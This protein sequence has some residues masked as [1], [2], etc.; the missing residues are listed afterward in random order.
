MDQTLDD[1]QFQA[2]I[3]A[4]PEQSIL[5]IEDLDRAPQFL[6]PEFVDDKEQKNRP[7]V[8][9][10]AMLQ[11]LS[12][13]GSNHDQIIFA[14][15]NNRDYLQDV[16]LRP[17]RVDYEVKFELASPRNL[18]HMFKDVFFEDT[19]DE[20]DGVARDGALF[21]SIVPAKKFSQSRIMNHLISHRRDRHAAIE[22]ARHWAVIEQG[23]E[24]ETKLG[25]EARTNNIEEEEGEEREEWDTQSSNASTSVE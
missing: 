6:K 12:G 14:T 25:N 22:N 2:M 20:K 4:V 23:E 24:R 5:L 9:L 18:E 19:D 7:R 21:A 17:G 16:L 15:T 3:H 11:V 1:N 8:S 10:M 13:L